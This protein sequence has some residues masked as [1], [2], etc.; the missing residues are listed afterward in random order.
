MKSIW[1]ALLL[2]VSVQMFAAAD[3]KATYLIPPQ[4][5]DLSEY[6]T[7]RWVRDGSWAPEWGGLFEGVCRGGSLFDDMSP[8]FRFFQGPDYYY[9]DNPQP[10]SITQ[11]CA[12]VE[13]ATYNNT[14]EICVTTNQSSDVQQLPEGFSV[15]PGRGSLLSTSYTNWARGDQK[16]HPRLH[17]Y[18]S[19]DPEEPHTIRITDG[20]STAVEVEVPTNLFSTCFYEY[21]TNLTFLPGSF[22]DYNRRMMA[23]VTATNAL[24]VHTYKTYYVDVTNRRPNRLFSQLDTTCFSGVL[25]D[26]ATDKQCVLITPQHVVFVSHWCPPS[27]SDILWF[28]KDGNRYWSQLSTA[29]N[30]GAKFKATYGLSPTDTGALIVAKLTTP[31]IGPTPARILST[32]AESKLRSYR[33][34]VFKPN[35]VVTGI[36]ANVTNRFH[37][38]YHPE[39]LSTITLV[40]GDMR[41]T[42]TTGPFPITAN[43]TA[44]P[45]SMYEFPDGSSW[46]GGG[47]AARD[48][49]GTYLATRGLTTQTGGGVNNA[50]YIGGNSGSPTFLFTDMTNSP[51]ILSV[52]DKSDGMGPNI[53]FYGPFLQEAVDDVGN[54]NN[55]E[56]EFEDLADWPD[57]E[58]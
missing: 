29:T 40:K 49:W 5:V 9:L 26:S 15:E 8:V 13:M 36:I 20:G 54:P 6:A 7:K 23:E 1:T 47:Q 52:L 32:N 31:V 10:H 27:D 21:A 42:R 18:P 25:K 39:G 58:Y 14:Y 4:L 41:T 45:D 57:Y 55:Y 46:N 12:V 22:R 48:T 53:T 11:A 34:S 30:L 28:D 51:V 38:D 2:L 44:S 3:D 24:E 33:D 19:D 43:V 56:V 37:L 17:L 50:P 16:G 35:T